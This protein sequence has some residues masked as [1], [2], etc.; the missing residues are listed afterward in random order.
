MLYRGV[1]SEEFNSWLN[2]N[3]IDTY[4][5]TLISDKTFNY[6]GDGHRIII[7]A[8]KNTKGFYIGNHSNYKSEKEFLIHRG[9]KYKILNNKNGVLEVEIIE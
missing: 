4:K 1:S 8:P 2:A 5:S 7:H 9:Q 6:F 3:V